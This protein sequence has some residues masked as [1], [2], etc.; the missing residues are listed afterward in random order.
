MNPFVVPDDVGRI[1]SKILS[2]FSGFTAEKWKK[3]I[4]TYSLPSIKGIVPHRDYD[5]WIMFVKACNLLYQWSL[6]TD[7]LRDGDNFLISF[8]KRFQEI[9]GGAQCTMNMHVHCHLK[10][11]V[12]DFGPV[13]AFWL[14]SFER[15]NGILGSF[16]TNNHDVTLQLMR[17]FLATS[18]H[19]VHNWPSEYKD[20]FLPVLHKQYS[21]KGSL[22]SET[23]KT[24][25]E[26][27]YQIVK[28]LAP[29]RESALQYFEKEPLNSSVSQI[30]GLSSLTI[31][32]LFRKCSALMIS[33]FVIGSKLS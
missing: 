15:L 24:A 4:L 9:Y 14:F 6:T 22:T 18:E 8:C 26:S 32:T 19:G 27:S 25:L 29:M 30:L 17:R 16:H 31:L 23:L 7:L 11:C 3:W 33:G 13:Y 12:E 2:G 21:C 5:C 10:E 28:P 20:E 1:P